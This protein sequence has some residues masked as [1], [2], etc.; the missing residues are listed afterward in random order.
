MDSQH[1]V[2]DA[3][4]QAQPGITPPAHSH[5]NRLIDATSPY[6]LQHAHNP[7][8]WHPWSPE[9][10]AKARSEN[11]PIFLSIGYSAC[12]WCHVM[13][14]EVFEKEEIAAIMNA[15]FINIKVD[16]EERPDLDELYMLATQVMSGS[17]GWPMSV[18]LTPDLKPFYA[19]TYFPPQDAYGRPG[20]PRL[21]LALADA[22]KNRRPDLL[23]QSQKGRRS[24]PHT[25]RRIHR[26]RRLPHHRSPGTGSPPP[27]NNTPL[28]NSTRTNTVA[29]APLPNSH[30][31]IRRST[32]GSPCCAAT[33]ARSDAPAR[34]EILKDM[35]TKTLDAMMRGGIYDHV[36][37][38]FKSPLLYRRTVARPAF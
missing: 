9:S 11:K 2:H 13:E 21:E 17:G 32:S 30:R 31:P 23:A 14:R 16:R 20:F 33:A 35:T 29:L 12:H 26:F 37:G 38:G 6:L 8:D 18:W 4:T 36:G 27:S 19:G 5:T 15:H 3:E 22:W 28:T 24:H 10:L 7:V 34:L 25:R 1:Q